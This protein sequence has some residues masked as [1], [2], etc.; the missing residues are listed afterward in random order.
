[1]GE[2]VEG[3]RHVIIKASSGIFLEELRKTMKMLSEGD[4]V[5]WKVQTEHLPKL[6]Q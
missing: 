2:N 5:V 1:M 3:S 4:L 6:N